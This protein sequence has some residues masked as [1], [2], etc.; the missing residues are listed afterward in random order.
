VA[1]DAACGEKEVASG[2]SASVKRRHASELGTCR[3]WAQGKTD[4]ADSPLVQWITAS[5]GLLYSQ[6][7]ARRGAALAQSGDE[8]GDANDRPDQQSCQNHDSKTA[9]GE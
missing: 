3:C 2:R 1:R 7:S 4:L 8:M 5:A 9:S 6:A